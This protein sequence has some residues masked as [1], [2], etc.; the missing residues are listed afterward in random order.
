MIETTLF[1][2]NVSPTVLSLLLHLWTTLAVTHFTYFSR[3]VYVFL[4][5]LDGCK[6]A[7][8]NFGHLAV[9]FRVINLYR[10]TKEIVCE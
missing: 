4:F 3:K 6:I 9:L 8:D 2:R 10:V 1:D 7:F 5:H